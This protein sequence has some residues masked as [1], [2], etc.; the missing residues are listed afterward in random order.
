ML[1]PDH[2]LLIYSFCF[3]EAV[4]IPHVTLRKPSSVKVVLGI[5]GC[6]KKKKRDV[7]C[8]EKL[9]VEMKMILSKREDQNKVYSSGI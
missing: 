9:K 3:R 1:S 7:L 8:Q 6:S 2:R 4:E 5:Y